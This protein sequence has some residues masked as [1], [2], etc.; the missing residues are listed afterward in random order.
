MNMYNL[1][2]Q[3]NRAREQDV[4]INQIQNFRDTVIMKTAEILS[5]N[6]FGALF[7][8]PGFMRTRFLSNDS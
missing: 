1:V 6:E 8:V 4:Q 5:I 7:S 3:G 2:L